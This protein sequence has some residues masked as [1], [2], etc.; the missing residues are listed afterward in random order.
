RMSKVLKCGQEIALPQGCMPG[1]DHD[2]QVWARQLFRRPPRALDSP[3]MRECSVIY[4]F[5][6]P[7]ERRFRREY[8]VI[9]DCTP[10]LMP[11]FHV[12]ETREK[13][14]ELFTHHATLCDKLIADSE[15]T[16]S[17]SRWLTRMPADKLVVISPGP[18]MCVRRHASLQ[19]MN[20]Q[21]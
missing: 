14:G 18:S 7:P 4:P 13:F 5:L 8:S 3:L 15:S 19:A 16:R 21:A 20:R 9:H 1:A 17:D 11:K 12:A 2:L 10:A 6:R